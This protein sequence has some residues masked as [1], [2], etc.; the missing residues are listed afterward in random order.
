MYLPNRHYAFY[1]ERGTDLGMTSSEDPFP[2]AIQK[3]D[4]P[5]K[6]CLFLGSFSPANI[7]GFA[8]SPVTLL[9]A[10]ASVGCNGSGTCLVSGRLV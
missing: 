2:S 6:H 1:S 8:A 5:L 10:A 7:S 3:T 9:W 4:G